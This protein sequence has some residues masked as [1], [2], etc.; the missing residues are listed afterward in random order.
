MNLGQ[1]EI[2]LI[3]LLREMIVHCLRI[4]IIQSCKKPRDGLAQPSHFT[5]KEFHLRAE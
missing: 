4:L 3:F 1:K 5:G 2:S